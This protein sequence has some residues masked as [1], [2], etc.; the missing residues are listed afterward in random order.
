MLDPVPPSLGLGPAC[1][2]SRQMCQGSWCLPPGVARG[3]LP[4]RNTTRPKYCCGRAL[5]VHVPE[6]LAQLDTPVADVSRAVVFATWCGTGCLVEPN[7]HAGVSTTRHEGRSGALKRVR[8]LS[9]ADFHNFCSGGFL[10]SSTSPGGGGLPV[11]SA[12]C[13]LVNSVCDAGVVRSSPWQMC[14]GSWC[15]PPGVA[16]GVLSNRITTGA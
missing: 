9:S 16:R 3:A 1:L 8:I 5:Q 6:C 2:P 14:W 7:Y 12:L 11:C 4:N 10:G 15:L 13:G